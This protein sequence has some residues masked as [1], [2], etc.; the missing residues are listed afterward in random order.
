MNRRSFI[1]NSSVL[2][3]ASMLPLTSFS[4]NDRPKFKMGY[5]LFSIR[6][7]MAKDPKS[8]L[9]YLKGLG[10]E[11]FEIYGFDAE[12][13]SYYGYASQAFKELLDQLGLTVSSGH[14]NFS[15][16]L[17]QSDAE[18]AQFV[19]R[20]IE[21]AHTL[22]S[23][24]ITLPWIAPEQRTIDSY[25]ILAGKM[26]AIG[27]QVTK[28]GLGFAYHNHGYEFEDQNGENGFDIL[29]NETDPALVKLQMDMYWVVRSSK[30]TPQ[31]LIRKQPK[32]YTMWHIKDMDKLSRDYTEL[33]NG[34]IDYEAILPDPK[35]SG[36][37]FYYIEQGG[38]YSENS[39]KSAASNAQYFRRRLQR[40]L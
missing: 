35:E 30:Y 1:K 7:Q 24:Y 14:Y 5:Q 26:N 28:A 10:Y 9:E 8:T 15:P 31:E 23:K 12:K 34:S 29:V 39:L 13:G 18:L 16:Y 19:D 20:C 40:Y 4:L 6:D 2:G 21:G 11:D 25:K 22:N 32:R 38:N 33:G 37:E 36:L 27:E 3:V 17:D